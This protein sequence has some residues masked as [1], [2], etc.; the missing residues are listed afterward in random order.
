MDNN[1]EI[2]FEEVRFGDISSSSKYG[3]I[4]LNVIDVF[5][6]NP[7]FGGEDEVVKIVAYAGNEIIGYTMPFNNR[8]LLNG[9]IIETQ[10]GCTLYAKEKYKKYAV[11][12]ELFYRIVNLHH[13]KNCCFAGISQK[14]LPLYKVLKL[15]IF[16]MFRFIYIR[17]SKSVFQSLFKTESKIINPI[18]IVV[19]C[20]LS[21]HRRLLKQIYIN[22]NDY[23]VELCDNV[24]DDV[25]RIV[26]EDS[27]PFMELHDKAW[28]EWVLNNSFKIDARL[29][30]KLFVVKINDKIEAF[31]VIKQEFFKQASAR[32]YKNVYLASIMEWGIDKNSCLTEDKLNMI[33]LSFV[34]DDV[35]AVQIAT[36]DSR[37]AK[38]YRMNLMKQ[39]GNA[40]MSVRVKSLIDNRLKDQNNWRLRMAAGDTML[41]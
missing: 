34:D 33:A 16:K 38:K 37:I 30:K 15:P 8:L 4:P 13:T 40:N 11:G 26:R 28:F 6:N 25:E 32:G 22:T 2:Q 9:E 1:L 7:S 12:A 31:F 24:P 20:I 39:M 41:D 3:S 23:R 17:H 19:D 21:I 14:A 29:K 10:S 36:D 5:R 35:D 18:I 27:H